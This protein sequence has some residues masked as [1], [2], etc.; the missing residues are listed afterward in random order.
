MSIL[1]W[2]RKAKR[3]EM[4]PHPDWDFETEAMREIGAWLG[5]LSE[6]AQLRILT[7]W[8]WRLKSKDRPNVEHWVESIA[9][10][11]AVEVSRRAGFREGVE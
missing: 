11:S 2:P 4:R 9:E 6:E 7:Y 5:Q 8:M 10:Q 3:E 1:P